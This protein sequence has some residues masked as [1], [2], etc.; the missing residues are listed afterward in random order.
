[1]PV[2]QTPDPTCPFCSGSGL[3]FL[4][5]DCPCAANHFVTVTP[6]D[7][8]NPSSPEVAE[9]VAALSPDESAPPIGPPASMSQTDFI[10]TLVSERD[11]A[12]PA[13]ANAALAVKVHLDGTRHLTKADA[14]KLIEELLTVPKSPGKLPVR[15]NRYAGECGTCG[16]PVPVGVGRI[17]KIDGKWKTFHL[18]GECLDEAGQVALAADKVSEPG[19]YKQGATF[20]RVRRGRFD[21][22]TFW[23]EKIHV[24]PTEVSFS[25]AGRAA[26]LRA[27]ERMSWKEA[28]D[29]GVAYNACINCGRSLSD[30]RSVVAG[31][32]ETCA[33]TCGWVYPSAKLAKAVLEGTAEW[34]GV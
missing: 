26:F 23:A 1:V 16:G 20:Y 12:H 34:E 25:R 2:T 3:T 6:E 5:E 4:M 24:S 21:K 18:D 10:T 29:L 19:V 33:N 14:S 31:Y 11:A 28:H 13:V 17:E 27:S 9:V 22:E 15:P 30:D 7:W 32:G 8:D